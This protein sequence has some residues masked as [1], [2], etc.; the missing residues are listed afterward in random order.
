MRSRR[1]TVVRLRLPVV[2]FGVVPV[3]H[4]D[5]RRRCRPVPSVLYVGPGR[6]DD[7]GHRQGQGEH[8]QH[9][10]QHAGHDQRADPAAQPRSGHRI[11][12]G[13]T[14]WPR[15]APS[16]PGLSR[17]DGR[18]ASSVRRARGL[19]VARARPSGQRVEV[20]LCARIA[21]SASGLRPGRA[22]GPATAP[23]PERRPA[24]DADR[25]R[26]PQRPGHAPPTLPAPG[27]RR[28]RNA[29]SRRNRTAAR[30]SSLL[31]WQT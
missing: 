9:E 28:G 1:S 14:G 17:R 4:D 29:G 18:S 12:R 15:A 6:E 21:A 26:Q 13:R 11:R 5:L 16:G 2:W 25:H 8:E 27:V 10:E 30:R 19:A 20:A 23:R 3:D 7:V 24:R 31:P 22:A